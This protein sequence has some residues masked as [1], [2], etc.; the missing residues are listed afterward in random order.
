MARSSETLTQKEID[1]YQTFCRE[2]NIIADES[3]AGLQNG[4]VIGTYVAITWN[5]DFTP[6]TLKTALDM[7]RDRIVF[8]TPAQA[9]YKKVADENPAAANQL[10]AWFENQNILVKEGDFGLQNQTTLL[11]EL[12][13]REITKDAIAVAIERIKGPVSKFHAARRPLHFV[14]APRRTEP[15][16]QHALGDDGKPF[17]GEHVNEPAWV[18]R[19]R[20]RSEREAAEAAN[21][22]SSTSVRSRA[23]AEAREKAE[24]LQSSTHAET[25][26]LR[27]IFV[28]SGTEIDWQATLASR[29]QMQKQFDKA[30]E[31]RRFVR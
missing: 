23:A 3:E 1:T 27:R 30:R 6:E 24:S 17:L 25:D 22:P 8:Y 31:V 15:I 19:S 10:N 14:Q 12:R 29:L 21:Q 11:T 4:E 2:H 16:S 18:K 28:T 5:V 13:G 20:K 7:L 26:Q 9:E